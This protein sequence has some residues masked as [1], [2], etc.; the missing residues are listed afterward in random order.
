MMDRA[1]FLEQ[2][3]LGRFKAEPTP[4][5]ARLFREV[6]S[7][8]TCDDAD[9]LV[10]NG[11]AGTGK[12]SAIAA[13]IAALKDVGTPSVLL[14]PTGRAAKVLSGFA[15]R[16]AFTIHKHIY[17]QKSVGSDG[18]GQFTLSPNKAKG[19]LFVVD[20]VS[21]I[22]ID[23]LQGQG[24]AAFGTG[25]LLEDLVSFV[26]NGLDCRLILVGDAAQLPPVGLDASP[27][28]SKDFMDGFGGVRYSTLTSVVRQAAESGIL[29]NATLLRELISGST[30]D[31]TFPDLRLDLRDAD[32]IERIGGGELIETL[33]DAYSRYGEDGTVILCRS[34]KRAIRYNL[35]VRATVQFK[36]ERLVRDDKLMIVKNCY[37][38]VEDVPGMDYIANGDIAKLVRIGRFEERY[39]LHFADATLL[40]P[41]YDD[42]EIKA[43]V[44][45]DTLESEAASLTYEQQNALYQGVSADYADRGT[46][47]KIWEAVR[48]D[49]YFN[50]LQLKYAE[51]ITCHKSQ[52]GQWDCVFIDCP[53]WQD[54][55]SLD[56]LKWLY[57]ALTRAVRKVYLVNFNNRFFV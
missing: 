31:S 52:G 27:A 6:A 51:A 41:D 8:V 22:G 57:T 18:F 45:L 35:G 14:A 2:R 23:S 44:C 9:I 36:E 47:K 42:V 34:N 38:F 7:F 16:P 1:G 56:D 17:R 13:V 39:G 19:T 12:T 46:K 33:S 37:Q 25:N 20:E 40:F 54:E 29:R 50:A 11:Y 5:Q 21:L 4:C 30:P 49:H 3:F 26:R 48:E 55:Q 10:V 15:R 53:F 43:K 32:D 28:L 24:S